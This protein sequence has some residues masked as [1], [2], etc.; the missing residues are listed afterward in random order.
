[1]GDQ[2][3]HFSVRPFSMSALSLSL[4]PGSQRAQTQPCQVCTGPLLAGAKIGSV[5]NVTSELCTR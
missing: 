1:M 5:R 4:L 2:P 3:G